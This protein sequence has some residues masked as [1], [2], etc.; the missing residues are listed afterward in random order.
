[1]SAQTW[2]AQ[3]ERS[4][5]MALRL[6]VWIA[7]R[8]GRRVVGWVL[9][10]VAFYFSVLAPSAR[11]AS[12]DYL[13]RVLHRP[14]RWRDT[15]WHF[16]YFARVAVDR[17]YLLAGRTQALTIVR[18]NDPVYQRYSN[19][20]QGVLVMV[21]HLGSFEALRVYG[22]QA[23]QLALKVLMDR[24]TRA[25]AN[26]VLEAINPVLCQAIIDTS[27]DDVD[28][29]LRVRDALEHRHMV[30][31]MA[32]RHHPG[33]RT[34]TCNFLGGKAEFPLA[35]WLL[36]TVMGAPVILGFSLYRGRGK[37]DL[38]VEEFSPALH[39]KRSE[40]IEQ[41]GVCAQQYADRLAEYVRKEP[42]NWFNFYQFWQP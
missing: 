41:A 36:A 40:R 17:I 15:F 24:A 14:P 21:A 22:T 8:L 25:K 7:L 19:A 39:F 18:H 37:Y 38:Y 32:D 4:T 12:R 6:L 23:D 26:A 27:G 9:Y 42:Y 10:P 16:R 35:P 30:G 5:R 29:V 33:E 1:M 34:V 11:R 2:T 28:R 3:G 20:D 13:A 31:I